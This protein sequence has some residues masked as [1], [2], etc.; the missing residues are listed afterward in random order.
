MTYAEMA[1]SNQQISEEEEDA[2]V[3]DLMGRLVHHGF[4]M[5]P[6]LPAKNCYLRNKAWNRETFV[7]FLTRL[8]R[9]DLFHGKEKQK[10]CIYVFH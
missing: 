8:P 3:T 2:L 9:L 10:V 6:L 4:Q 1:S 7:H 5:W